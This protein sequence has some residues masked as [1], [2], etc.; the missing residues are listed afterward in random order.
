[1]MLLSCQNQQK[2]IVYYEYNGVVITR[3]NDFP[4]D[5]FYYGKFDPEVDK[6]PES[7]IESKFSGFDGGMGAYLIFKPNKHVEII[8]EW[9]NFSPVR[10]K[11]N[12]I[13]IDTMENIKFIH[14]RDSAK[15]N[16]KNIAYVSHVLDLERKTNSN[17]KSQVT[18]RIK[19]NS[20]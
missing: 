1:M 20:N 4:K 8:R 16:L 2:K 19:N 13:L 9:G 18:R 17:E 10:L 11:E 15:G 7:Y 14:W 6:L 5:R 12:L 3:I